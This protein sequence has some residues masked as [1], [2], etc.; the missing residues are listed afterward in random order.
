MSRRA[1]GEGSITK[2]SFTSTEGKIYFRWQAELL[3]GYDNE[4]KRKRKFITGKTQAEVREK[5]EE[6]KQQLRSGTYVESKETVGQYLGKWLKEKAPQLKERTADDY[7]YSLDKYVVPR[8]GRVR[9]AKLTPLALQTM[10]REIAEEVSADRANKC[11]RILYGALKQAV[12]WQ[13]IPRNPV[14][15]V[16][17]MKH[18]RRE[19][20]V[21][22][23][24]EVAQ[25]LDTARGHRLYALF[26]LAMSTGLRCGEM[27]GLKW[28]DLEG[29]VLHVNRSL[30][31][32]RGKL[33][34]STPK[35]KKGHRRVALSP[36]V[37]DVLAQHRERQNAERTFLDRAWPELDLVFP[38]T[39]GGYIH[40]RN[41][42]RAWDTLQK[43]A[44]EACYKRAL[45]QDDQETLDKLK[46]SR[47]L[48]HIRLHDLRHLHASIAIRSGMDP[49]VLADRL[50][51]ARASFTL[52]VYTHLFDEQRA[53]SAVSIQS[54]IGDRPVN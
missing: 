23:A 54:L 35:T 33:L 41:L 17:A 50:G 47:L 29:N 49:K 10:L 1:K 39:T 25:F 30:G 5:L 24:V 42:L 16:D 11:R 32:V 4:G 8:I 46:G 20:R 48:P 44:R 37:I 19:M 22:S 6:A 21:W 38:S 18:E 53:N 51:H 2:R 40:P 34:V 14:E 45:E 27:L 13:L 7:L 52:D 26:Y 28:S 15:A 31:H 43:S 36:D 3:V 9:L 12:R